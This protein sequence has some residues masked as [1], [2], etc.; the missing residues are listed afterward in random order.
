MHVLNPDDQLTPCLQI[1][2]NSSWGNKLLH[3]INMLGRGEVE[4]IQGN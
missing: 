1:R 2:L 3:K 4:L